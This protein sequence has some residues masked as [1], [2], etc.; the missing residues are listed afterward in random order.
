MVGIDP[1]VVVGVVLEEVDFIGES[2]LETLPEIEIR[3]VGVE[4]PV[5]VGGIEKP[6]AALLVGNDVDNPADGVGTEADG[7]DPLVDF[8]A[9]GKADGYVVEPEGAAHPLLRHAVDEYLHV[10][11]AES[12]EHELHVG[13]HAARFA[14][15]HTRG[16]GQGVAQVL[17]RVAHLAGIDRHG[18]VGRTF[19]PVHPGSDY[20]HL[21]ESLSL[22]GEGD[23]EVEAFAPFQRNRFLEGLVAD[24]RDHQRVV[25]GSGFETVSALFVGCA[26]RVPSFEVDGGKVDRLDGSPLGRRDPARDD[27]CGRVS[28][29]VVP[30]LSLPGE[31]AER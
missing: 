9:V 15:L 21:V 4:R 26:A 6:V 31:G 7:Y 23:V 20:R 10:L 14:Q 27:G 29:P 28:L 12:V 5:G 19:H 8:D 17:G 30:V 3:L 24:G 2:A 22:W 13:A 18:V 25:A 1:V 16:F 11:A